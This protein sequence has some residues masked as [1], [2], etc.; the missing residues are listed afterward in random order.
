MLELE[1][2]TGVL[3]L[4][5]W[6]KSVGVR[7]FNNSVCLKVLNRSVGRRVVHKEHWAQSVGLR[8]GTTNCYLSDV[9]LLGSNFHHHF[10][11]H[12]LSESLNND[13][14]KHVKFHKHHTHMNALIK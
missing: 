2:L 13:T 8:L 5:C 4:K 1:C 7:L 10:T 6:T 12:N 11:Y 14:C 3:D 9:Q